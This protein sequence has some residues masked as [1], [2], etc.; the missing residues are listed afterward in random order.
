MNKTEYLAKVKKAFRSKGPTRNTTNAY[1]II[2]GHYRIL[3]FNIN[4]EYHSEYTDIPFQVVVTAKWKESHNDEYLDEL[5]FDFDI[6]SILY[7]LKKYDEI[8]IE[9]DMEYKLKIFQFMSQHY[10]FEFYLKN[11][12]L[13]SRSHN[14]MNSII[15]IDNRFDENKIVY[16]EKISP[17]NDSIIKDDSSGNTIY[18]LRGSNQSYLENLFPGYNVVEIESGNLEDA[19]NNEW[20]PENYFFELNKLRNDLNLTMAETVPVKGW[21][22]FHTIRLEKA[23]TMSN[24]EPYGYDSPCQII[25]IGHWLPYNKDIQFPPVFDLKSKHNFEVRLNPL[26]NKIAEIDDLPQGIYKTKDINEFIKLT[27]YCMIKINDV[28]FVPDLKS[29]KINWSVKSPSLNVEN[30][31]EEILKFK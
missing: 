23:R 28:S 8:P 4:D 6:S 20:L 29:Y 16:N 1:N 13:E 24:G 15:V 25:G 5:T 11:N 7:S 22:N 9:G 27:T 12:N 2:E 31:D 17:R 26:F 3:K 14:K 18:V 21:Y 10:D 19:F 30:I